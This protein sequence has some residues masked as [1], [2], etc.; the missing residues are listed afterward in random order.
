MQIPLF[1]W[2][3][4]K[5]IVHF[6]SKK[7]E[8]ERI[9]YDNQIKSFEKTKLIEDSIENSKQLIKIK[10]EME[11]EFDSGDIAIKIV[12]I[13]NFNQEVLT[14]DAT[15]LPN[16]ISALEPISSYQTFKKV[17]KNKQNELYDNK[18][19][20]HEDMLELL[21]QSLSPNVRRSAR[22]SSEWGELGFQGKDPATDFRG[23]G[24]LGLENLVYLSTIHSDKARDALNNSRSKCQ[25]PFA[26]TGINI[27]ALVSKLMKISSYKIHFYKVGSNIEQFNELYAR[28]FISFDRYY[29]NKNPVN[30]MSFGPIMKDF[31]T[32]LMK[33]FEI[34]SLYD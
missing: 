7:S 11:N 24:I 2:K 32:L 1:L 9:C 5:Y 4:Y 17:I 33:D 15:I 19:Q 25:Y 31:E 13:K 22:F 8:I 12:E 34:S 10:T 16:L 26:I 20:E 27:T 29:Q 14:F 3:I 21:W 18:N 30:V 6:F 23:M 28:I